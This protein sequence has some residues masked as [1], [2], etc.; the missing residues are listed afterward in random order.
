MDP[1][2]KDSWMHCR[3]GVSRREAP[4]RFVHYSTRCYSTVLATG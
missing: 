4:F 1:R 2:L 3:K